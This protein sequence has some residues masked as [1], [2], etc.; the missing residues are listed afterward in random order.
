MRQMIGDLLRVRV[1]QHLAAGGVIVAHLDNKM[2]VWHRDI[3]VSSINCKTGCAMS[4]HWRGG[5]VEF[6]APAGGLGSLDMPPAVVRLAV[7]GY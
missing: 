6:A 4:Y 7:C 5:R 1:A 3:G 2:E